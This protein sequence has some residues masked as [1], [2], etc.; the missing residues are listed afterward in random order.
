MNPKHTA[1]LTAVAAAICAGTG[2]AAPIPAELFG[3]NIEHTRSAVQSGLSAQMV[4]NRKFAGKPD[5]RGVSAMWESYGD[6]ALYNLADYS[7]TR[8]ASGSRMP[9]QNERRSQEIQCLDPAGEAGIAQSRIG[10]RG[11]VKHTLSIVASTYHPEDT[12]VILRVLAENG[13]PIAKKEFTLNTPKNTEWKRLSMDF[14]PERDTMGTVQ[15]G[16][17]GRKIFTVGVVSLL[18]EDNFRGMR[19]DVIENLKEIGSS[20]IRWPGGNFAG[21][22]RWRDGL[23]E[24][25]DER[26]PL[27]SYTEIETQPHSCGYDSN[28]IGMEDIIALCDRIGARPFF[29]IN[30]AWDGPEESAEWVKACKGRVKLWSLGNEMGYSH[31]EVAK[32]FAGAAGYVR[33]VTPH[34]EAMKAV[35]P[36]IELVQSG[37]FPFGGQ[38]WIDDSAVPLGAKAPVLS[39]H[40]YDRPKADNVFDY[41]TPERA[42]ALFAGAAKS[43]DKR[44][45]NLFSFR[46]K[47]PESIK[48]S[49]DEW[50]FWYAWYRDEGIVEGLYAAKLVT[51][52]MQNWEKLGI[53]YM[54]YFQAINEHAIEV[55]PFESHLT[56]IGEAMRMMKG[57]VGGEPCETENLPENAFA[58]DA[59]DG[60][61]YMTFMNFSTVKPETFKLRAGGRTKIAGGELL[62][63]ENG[64]E[65]GCRYSRRPVEAKIADDAC[66]ITL[67]PACMA[68]VRLGR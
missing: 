43:V 8:H 44:I 14:T 17:R 12:P 56:S 7:Y 38:K 25:A 33:M 32:E 68:S 42:E 31:M 55:G 64:I 62:V 39:Y 53:K 2:E 15:I 34:I 59:P 29:T 61:R 21:E 28:D 36:G 35:D 48:L 11:G 46:K 1:A 27:Q 9:R 30:A 18:P 19:P 47:I 63:P 57:H 49:Y 50:N 41:T 45:N 66:E 37:P 40:G 13:R 51:R 5:R 52:I 3:Q 4:R 58:T 6:R 20:V 16:V 60:T 23:I 54:C 22:Y 26:A 24:N 10:M 67:G 65:G